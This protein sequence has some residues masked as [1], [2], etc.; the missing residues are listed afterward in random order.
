MHGGRLPDQLG[1]GEMRLQS[2]SCKDCTN[3]CLLMF[4]G[5]VFEYCKPAIAGTCRTEWVTDTYIDC[6]DYT[7]DAKAYDTQARLHPAMLKGAEE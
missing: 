5:E 6:L 7:T 2:W 1:R 4:D 3:R